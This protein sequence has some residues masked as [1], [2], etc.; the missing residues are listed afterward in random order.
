MLKLVLITFFRL[1]VNESV[2]ISLVGVYERVGKSVIL[3]CKKAQK[4]QMIHFLTVKESRKRSGFV[5]YSFL[6][7]R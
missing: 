6:M 7:D 5:I 2:G 1:Q 3:V 4:V